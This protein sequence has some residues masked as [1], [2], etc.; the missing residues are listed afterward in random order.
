[1]ASADMRICYDERGRKYELPQFVIS[2]PTN[3]VRDG[4]KGSS[5]RRSGGGGGAQL[6]LP[7]VAT[8]GLA[9]EAPPSQMAVR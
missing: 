2:E 5:P 9:E 8:G 7:A 3:L 1:M 4:G 6:E